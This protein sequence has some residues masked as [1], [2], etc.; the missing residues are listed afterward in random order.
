M[1]DC[2]STGSIYIELFTTLHGPPKSKFCLLCCLEPK[3]R[4]LLINTEQSKLVQEQP[5]MAR[6][7]VV[8]DARRH[9]FLNYDSYIDCTDPFGHPDID[10]FNERVRDDGAICKGNLR[11]DKI[12][13][14]REAIRTSPTIV[15]RQ[16]DWMLTGLPNPR[17]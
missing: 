12:I 1:I 4:F 8:I 11:D 15:Q 2:L 17:L 9:T 5:E 16:Q 10:D 3:P 7:Q 6:S 13:L 14:V